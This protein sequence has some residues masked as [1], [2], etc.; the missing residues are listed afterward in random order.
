[1]SFEPSQV[2]FVRKPKPESVASGYSA[3]LPLGLILVV[4]I[5]STLR[6]TINLHR[7]E[8]LVRA[9]NAQA[10]ERLK[11][12]GEE[13]ALVEKL[14]AGLAKLAAT[15]PVAAQI[16]GDFFP[17]GMT[18]QVENPKPGGPLPAPAK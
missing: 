18:P 16:Q 8:V 2:P 7:H 4:L 13:A 11:K 10:G 9:Q 14:R 12:V 1:M 3:F 5:L 17:T 6:D 15:D